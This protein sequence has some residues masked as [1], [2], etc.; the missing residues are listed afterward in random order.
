MICS[1]HI[2]LIITNVL[3]FYTEFQ[4]PQS[5]YIEM[6]THHILLFYM[7]LTLDLDHVWNIYVMLYFVSRV[8]HDS[9][10]Y[11]CK[12]CVYI[13]I[14]LLFCSVIVSGQCSY[15]IHMFRIP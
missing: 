3:Y 7:R 5:K 4:R 6:N 12:L 10:V 15:T 14:N 8:N 2:R 9:I 1:T 11:I 13:E